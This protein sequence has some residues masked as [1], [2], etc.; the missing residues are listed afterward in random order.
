[1]VSARTPSVGLNLSTVFS[2]D[3]AFTIRAWKPVTVRP[4]GQVHNGDRSIARRWI[5][6]SV[7]R[8][9]R[10]SCSARCQAS[11]VPAGLPVVELDH[12]RADSRDRPRGAIVHPDLQHDVVAR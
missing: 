10:R 11:S 2:S 7:A 1:M 3:C 8:P 12:E 5:Q 6:L 4:V 9:V